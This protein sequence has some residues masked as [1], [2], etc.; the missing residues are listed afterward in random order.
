MKKNPQPKGIRCE[1][2]GR[3]ISVEPYI[4]LKW[5]KN[6]KLAW[7]S[8]E[9]KDNLKKQL[10]GGDMPPTD[11]RLLSEWKNQQG[12]NAELQEKS[13]R[14]K[15]EFWEPLISI[16]IPAVKKQLKVKEWNYPEDVWQKIDKLTTPIIRKQNLIKYPLAEDNSHNRT[17]GRARVIRHRKNISSDEVI[18]LNKKLSSSKP[19]KYLK[20]PQRFGSNPGVIETLREAEEIKKVNPKDEKDNEIKE[21]SINIVK[22]LSSRCKKP[23]AY[24]RAEWI[25]DTLGI[26]ETY[27]PETETRIGDASDVSIP[28]DKFL[29]ERIRKRCERNKK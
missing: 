1:G 28:K 4:Y 8:P 22:L 5:H 18:S 15:K 2:C 17:L 12:L 20:I 3:D 27:I 21:A 16:K 11:K 13:E 24:K 7:C 9:C 23:E 10:T 6:A 19:G 29:G 25:L 26:E 14:E